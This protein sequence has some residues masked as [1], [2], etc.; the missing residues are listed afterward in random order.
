ML[1]RRWSFNIGGIGSIRWSLIKRREVEIFV[2]GAWNQF[3]VLATAVTD[4]EITSIINHVLNYPLGCTIPHTQI[5]LL[6]VFTYIH[7][8]KKIVRNLA[9]A[10]FVE[11]RVLN[12]VI[13]VT[14][15]TSTVTS[16]VLL[17]HSPS[18]LKSMTT[19]W[20]AFGSWWSS[21]ATSVAK[22]AICPIFVSNAILLYIPCPCI[23]KVDHHNHPL[24][25]TPSL[26][27]H[28]SD[29]PICRLCVRKMDILYLYYCSRCDFVAHL[30]CVVLD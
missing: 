29:S 26:E 10:T 18:K 1:P 16:D 24:H 28:Q 25:L 20:P 6:F 17:S 2:R 3:L 22:K 27:V 15:A 11:K 21:L 19:N 9:N 14:V 7:I 12:T 8:T 4:V 5:I 13:V 23:L 30:Y